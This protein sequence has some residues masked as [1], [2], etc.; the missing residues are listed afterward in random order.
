MFHQIISSSFSLLTSILKRGTGDSYNSPEQLKIMLGRIDAIIYAAD[1]QTFELLFVNQFGVEMFG[2][3]KG[4]KCWEYLQAGQTGPCPFCTND[5]LVDAEGNPSDGYVWDFQNTITGRWNQCRDSAIRWTDGRVVRLEIA[6]DITDRKNT[7]KQLEKICSLKEKLI[8]L[9]SL[10]EKLTLITRSA[11]EIFGVDIAGIWLK[12]EGDTCEKCKFAQDIDGEFLCENRSSCLHLVAGSGIESPHL[13]EYKRTPLGWSKIGQLGAS[14]DLK[15]LYNTEGTKPFVPHSDWKFSQDM[16]AFAGYRLIGTDGNTTGVLAL[17]RRRRIQT[18]EEK[19]ME[20][21]ANTTS[22]VLIAGLAEKALEESE[23]RYRTLVESIPHKIYRKDLTFTYIGCNNHFAQDIHLT[24]QEIIGKTDYDLFP[25]DI[26]DALREDD[27]RLIPSGKTEEFY[28]RY[29]MDGQERWIYTVK[30]PV[31]DTNGE[32]KN[33]IGIFWDITDKIRAEEDLKTLS[34]ELEERVTE[35]TAQLSKT[36]EAFQLANTKL[37]LLNSITRHDILNLITGLSGY[38]DLTKDLTTDETLL[39]YITHAESAAEGIHRH[40]LFTKLYQDIG[41]Y[42][43]S[44][45]QVQEIINIAIKSI[46][47]LD[48]AFYGSIDDIEIYADPLL[49]KVFYTL[50]ENTLRHGH[51]AT[52]VI[53]SSIRK[54]NE[55]ILVYEDNGTGVEP[56]EKEQIF[57]RGYG[58]NTGFGLYLAREILTITGMSIKET[59]VQGKGARFEITVP[60]QHYRTGN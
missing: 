59:G 19:F 15:Y 6:T 25:P 31:Y 35:R 12:K 27:I 30:T 28:E 38:L 13:R 26:A 16:N 21:L 52:A 2:P 45:Q 9:Q 54:E 1:M 33:F 5:I 32:F 23:N 24:E 48:I 49:E 20:D 7:E 4:K 17:F 11:V 50:I 10:D 29:L 37:N 43:P 36:Q 14:N 56:R 3:Y 57:E 58:K 46:K 60:A 39:S 44:W 22:Q 18:E 53:F 51:H 40:I 34:T 8:G 42:S 55:L 41:V 47:S